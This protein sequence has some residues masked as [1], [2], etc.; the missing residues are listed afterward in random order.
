MSKENILDHS[1]VN[2]D[3]LNG[4]EKKVVLVLMF[5]QGMQSEY[6]VIS[7]NTDS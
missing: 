4:K 3:V 2:P 7:P 5:L 6:S 1:V